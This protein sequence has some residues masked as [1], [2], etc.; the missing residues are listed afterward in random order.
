MTSGIVIRE[1]TAAEWDAIEDLVMAAYA[2]FRPLFPERA[3][4]G[5]ME[6]I[7]QVIHAET[8]VL[9][10]ATEDGGIR[11]VVK[12]YPEASQ[13]ALGTWPAGAAAIRILAVHPQYRG[14]GLGLLLAQECLR[15]ARALKIPVIFLYTGEFMHAARHIYEKLGFKRAPEFDRSPG[16]I[17][18]RLDMRG[19]GDN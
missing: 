17:A 14:H 19:K 8:G 6:N 12:F 3:W 16:P 10:V 1:A 7:R 2:E 15:R 13:S 9:I 11:G 5:W 18:Y 4:D